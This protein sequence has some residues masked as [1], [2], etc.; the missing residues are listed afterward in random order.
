MRAIQIDTRSEE[1]EGLLELVS[2]SDFVIDR[3]LPDNVWALAYPSTSNQS[4]R[5]A[6][7]ALGAGF[8]FVEIALMQKL[9][10]FLGH[11]IYAVTVVLTSLLAFAGLGSLLA[12]RFEEVTRQH[13]RVLAVFVV[14]LVLAVL[15]L[16]YA[17]PAHFVRKGKLDDFAARCGTAADDRPG[18][19]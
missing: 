19:R 9:V 2:T 7:A 6:F 18:S 10:L 16:S 3:T 1:L 5:A 13:I 4:Y 15:Y 14:G 8:M 12:G 11:P 17:V